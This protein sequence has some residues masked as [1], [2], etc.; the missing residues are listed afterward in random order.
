M[1]EQVGHGAEAVEE[2]L[3]LGFRQRDLVE[4][5]QQIRDDQQPIDDRRT[6]GTNGVAQGE[7]AAGL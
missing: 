6:P 1:E 4:E 5:H 7:Q 2:A 3:E